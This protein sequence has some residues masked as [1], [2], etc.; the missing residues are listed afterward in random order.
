MLIQWYRREARVWSN[1]CIKSFKIDNPKDHSYSSCTSLNINRDHIHSKNV[2]LIFGLIQVQEI[3]D[4]VDS[5][6]QYAPQ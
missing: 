4:L 5:V 2:K 6:T 3:T 1:Y